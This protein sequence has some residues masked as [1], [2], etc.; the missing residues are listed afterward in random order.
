MGIIVWQTMAD[1]T[2]IIYTTKP[3]KIYLIFKLIY[4]PL[5]V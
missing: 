1:A 5:V 4:R 2:C 3:K